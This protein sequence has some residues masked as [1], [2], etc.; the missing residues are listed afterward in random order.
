MSTCKVA[1][2]AVHVLG[3]IVQA[4]EELYKGYPFGLK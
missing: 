4:S 2:G 3:G 1:L